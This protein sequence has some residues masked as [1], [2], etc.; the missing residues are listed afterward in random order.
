[1]YEISKARDD[2]AA[3]REERQQELRFELLEKHRW[4]LIHI[5]EKLEATDYQNDQEMITEHRSGSD[6]GAWILKSPEF[7]R[8]TDR[9]IREH[10]VL[11]IHGIPGAGEPNSP[12]LVSGPS[13]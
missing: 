8:W 7:V 9:S 3:L 1:M 5:R 4:R 13:D 10:D 6:S 11:Y 12:S 2:I